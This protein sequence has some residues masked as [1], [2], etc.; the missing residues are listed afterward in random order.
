MPFEYL[1]PIG[2][3]THILRAHERADKQTGIV[4]AFT[5]H[6]ACLLRIWARMMIAVKFSRNVS[7][8]STSTVEYRIGFVA[9]TSGDWVVMT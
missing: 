8:R 4:R 7:I 9:S 5:G 6:S 1:G 2:T 3:D